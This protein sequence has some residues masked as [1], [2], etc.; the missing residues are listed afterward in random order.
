MLQGQQRIHCSC[1]IAMENHPDD[2]LFGGE[3][4]W[5][6]L[7]APGSRILNRSAPW[8]KNGIH[9]KFIALSVPSDGSFSESLSDAARTYCPAGNPRDVS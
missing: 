5:T 4:A 1:V 2:A 7:E 6:Q 8:G 9:L 3:R